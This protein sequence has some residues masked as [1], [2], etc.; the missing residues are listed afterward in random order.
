MVWRP[1]WGWQVDLV[2]SV[3]VPDMLP[4]QKQNQL[5]THMQ[6]SAASTCAAALGALPLPRCPPRPAVSE[7]AARG[8]EWLHR[9]A[10]KP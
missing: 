7:G 2:L 10:S 3:Q 9:L 5:P 1:G 6:A 8:P 4:Q